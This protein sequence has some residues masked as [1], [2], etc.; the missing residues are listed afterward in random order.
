MHSSMV[1]SEDFTLIDIWYSER[2]ERVGREM[3]EMKVLIDPIV[4]YRRPHRTQ[5]HKYMRHSYSRPV[6]ICQV[7]FLRS[8]QE[9]TQRVSIYIE[10]LYIFSLKT[11]L[12][13]H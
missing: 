4:T 5:S 8:G 1:V 2:S 10:I 7:A 6:L 9:I 3:N 11:M 13:S 12:I